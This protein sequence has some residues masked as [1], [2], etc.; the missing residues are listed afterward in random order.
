MVKGT[1]GIENEVFLSPA[2][3]LNAGGLTN[4]INQKLKADEVAQL[5][6][7][8]DAQWDIQKDLQHL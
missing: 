6:K 7:S 2:R 4:I 1:W 8:A 5:K 3:I